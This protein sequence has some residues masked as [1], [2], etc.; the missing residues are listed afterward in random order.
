MHPAGSGLC[1]DACFS[2]HIQPLRPP[3]VD[4]AAVD[5]ASWLDDEHGRL[6]TPPGAPSLF[7]ASVGSFRRVR[8]RRE[9]HRVPERARRAAEEAKDAGD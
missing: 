3:R 8:A 9:R 2:R 4:Y 5:E 6:G 1:C 7:F